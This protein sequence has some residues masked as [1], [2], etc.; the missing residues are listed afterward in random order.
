MTGLGVAKR[1]RD[2]NRWQ[3]VTRLEKAVF[4]RNIQL[5]VQPLVREA[6]TLRQAMQASDSPPSELLSTA[7]RAKTFVRNEAAAAKDL[8]AVCKTFNSC[9]M[10]NES[11]LAGL[12]VAANGVFTKYAFSLRAKDNEANAVSDVVSRL[13]SEEGF[14][15]SSNLS[16]NEAGLTCQRKDFP[17]MAQTGYM[18]TEILCGVVFTAGSGG[19]PVTGLTRTFLGNGLGESREEALSEARRKLAR[20]SEQ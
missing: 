1:C 3:V 14:A 18:V 13:L 11:D 8:I 4:F 7:A 6:A 16:G 2:G 5:R 17:P 10:L 9:A 20:H 12:E 15:I 19:D